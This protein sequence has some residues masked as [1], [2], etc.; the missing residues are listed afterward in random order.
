MREE[1]GVPPWFGR[2]SSPRMGEARRRE[3]REMVGGERGSG[4][5]AASVGLMLQ[6]REGERLAVIWLGSAK[7]KVEALGCGGL[8]DGDPDEGGNQW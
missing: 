1:A 6:T 3:S 2:G 8:W 5:G 7:S 4:L